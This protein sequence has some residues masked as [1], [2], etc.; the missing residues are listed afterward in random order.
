MLGSRQQPESP[1]RGLREAPPG[2]F[3]QPSSTPLTPSINLRARLRL[4]KRFPSHPPS[5]S[6]TPSL[7]P[8]SLCRP[9]AATV[10]S[11]PSHRSS[12]CCGRF[13]APIRPFI[14]RCVNPGASCNL[15]PPSLILHIPFCAPSFS[16]VPP[17]SLASLPSA[18]ASPFHRFDSLAAR[19]RRLVKS[20]SDSGLLLSTSSLSRVRD[21]LSVS[22]PS[23]RPPSLVFHPRL[24]FRCAPRPRHHRHLATPL[25]A[26]SWYDLTS[27]L[28]SL[29]LLTPFTVPDPQSPAPGVLVLDCQTLPQP[30]QVLANPPHPVKT[31]STS[32]LVLSF[33]PQSRVCEL[34]TSTVTHSPSLTP[35]TCIDSQ[36]RQLTLLPRPSFR[37]PVAISRL[38]PSAIPHSQV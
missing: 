7:H 29:A 12:D 10:I 36:T 21:I 23:R 35:P 4:F 13:L 8:S 28:F 31:R 1:S 2:A 25:D 27:L 15:R 33:L 6:S 19:V 20:L 32:S 38:Y 3:K 17:T 5:F 14:P 9:E 16:P 22:R 34:G 37:T 18:S 26:P 24:C 11:T 30:T